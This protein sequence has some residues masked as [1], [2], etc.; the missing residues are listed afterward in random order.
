MV[1]P[2]DAIWLVLGIIIVVLLSKRAPQV[3]EQG[4]RLFSVEEEPA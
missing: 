1:G 4:N 3:L 2:I